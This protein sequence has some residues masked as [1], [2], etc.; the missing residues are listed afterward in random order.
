MAATYNAI[1]FTA[2]ARHL[3]NAGF[4]PTTI[5]T[6]E[7]HEVVFERR[8]HGD[9][10]LVVLVYTSVALR[11]RPQ[12]TDVGDYIDAAQYAVRGK[13]KDAIRVCLVAES[14]H[15]KAIQ[16]RR[17]YRQR[18]GRLGLGKAKRINRVGTEQ[19]ILDR[20]T[21][22]ARDMYRLANKIHLN[23][24]EGHGCECGAPTF[25]DSGKCVLRGYCNCKDRQ[26][27]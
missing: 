19:S 18:D 2:L 17:N 15:V 11:S 27:A 12:G 5:Y 1:A 3:V 16:E 23:R 20:I 24:I 8:H 22:R 25:P 14:D 7:G 26:A 4:T 10:Q 13:G 6:R 21:D 9:D